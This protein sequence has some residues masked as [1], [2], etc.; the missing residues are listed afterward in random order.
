MKK[1]LLDVKELS[2]EFRSGNNWMEVVRGVSYSIEMGKTLG[3]V[4]ESGCGK[5]VTSNALMGLLPPS[6]R[7]KQGEVIFKGNNLFEKSEKEMQ[8]IRG[9]D[10]AM[11]FQ[12]PM[13]ALNPVLKIGYQISEQI[14]RHLSLKKKEVRER[15]LDMLNNVKIPSP[16]KC[17]DLYPHQLS[18]GMRQ[19]VMIAMALSCSP[20]LL[21]ADEPTTALD[22]TIQAQIIDLLLFLQ[23]ESQ[24]AIQ[25]ISHDMGVISE[26]ADVVAVM[27]AGKICEMSSV[28]EIFNNPMHP[29]TK[30]L[31]ASI[32]NISVSKPR[33]TP[34]P[35]NLPKFSEIVGGCAF[36][37]RC[38]RACDDCFLSSPDLSLT[39]DNHQ[40]ACYNPQVYKTFM[41]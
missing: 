40:L 38:S 29:Y 7:I 1:K 2:V 27:Y 39:K 33:L 6:G 3:I 25:F 24:M 8:N 32:P 13:T 5:T 31:L 35:G 37:N 19:R 15:T 18:G 17:V 30:G 9:K 41:L 21:I 11:I 14:K 23:D 26:I 34:I 16:S 12:E 22:V 36:R 28:D 20:K 10:I 4:G